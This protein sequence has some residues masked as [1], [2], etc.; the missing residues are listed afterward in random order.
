LNWILCCIG[1][2]G[3]VLK[4]WVDVISGGRGDEQLSCGCVV[5]IGSGGCV[6]DAVAVVQ[7]RGDEGEDG[8]FCG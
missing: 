7:S 2:P 1:E 8:C 4:D 3:E 5:A 6:Q